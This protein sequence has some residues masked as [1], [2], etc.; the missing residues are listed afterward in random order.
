MENISAK[1][2]EDN[3]F[4]LNVMQTTKQIL[5]DIELF[6]LLAGW[7]QRHRWETFAWTHFFWM[8]LQQRLYPENSLA[9][10]NQY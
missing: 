1:E 2:R 5:H 9:K 3:S 8:L 6:H 10:H 7:I 4:M